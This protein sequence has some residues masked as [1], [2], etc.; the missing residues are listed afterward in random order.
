MAPKSRTH[1]LTR[2]SGRAGLFGPLL[3][4]LFSLSHV[5]L[6]LLAYWAW[7][8]LPPNTARTGEM[9]RTSPKPGSQ[10]ALFQVRC[11]TLASECI[12]GWR[13]DASGATGWGTNPSGAVGWVMDPS[14]AAGWGTGASGGA[15]WSAADNRHEIQYRTMINQAMNANRCSGKFSFIVIHAN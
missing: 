3:R 11:L 14:G 10:P 5:Q 6:G 9:P 15:G 4:L 2:A 8:S 12:G 13:A 7:P 1:A